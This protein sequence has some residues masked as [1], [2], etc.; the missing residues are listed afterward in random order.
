MDHNLVLLP[1]AKPSIAGDNTTMSTSSPSIHTAPEIAESPSLSPKNKIR[2]SDITSRIDGSDLGGML[3]L[4]KDCAA[5]EARIKLIAEL[6]TKNIG[7]NE[8]EQFGL[9]L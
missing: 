1:S 6:K 3:K 9:G 2:Y 5:S 4:W 8:I 7:F